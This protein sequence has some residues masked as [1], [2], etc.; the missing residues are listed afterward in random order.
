MSMDEIR[1]KVISDVRAAMCRD[2]ACNML[3]PSDLRVLVGE[4]DRLRA[5]CAQT[6]AIVAEGA[7]EG[8]NPLVGTWA[9]RLFANQWDL[10]QAAK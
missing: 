10:S 6:N 1:S 5:V 2:D 3:V 9:E 8:F 4:I 7:K